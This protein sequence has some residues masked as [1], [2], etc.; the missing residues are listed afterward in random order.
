[1]CRAESKED[2][3][4]FHSARSYVM[5]YEAYT[6]SIYSLSLHP[7]D[8]GKSVTF[9]WLIWCFHLASLQHQQHFKGVWFVSCFHLT[10]LKQQQGLKIL[11]V[12]SSLLCDLNES[13]ITLPGFNRHVKN[14]GALQFTDTHTLLSFYISTFTS[15]AVLALYVYDPVAISLFRIFGTPDGAS[16]KHV[17]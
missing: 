15:K 3:K 7:F 14:C 12:Y 6:A 8:L 10:S 5:I 17:E 11:T 9:Q 16:R 2:I 1:M 13:P 4:Q